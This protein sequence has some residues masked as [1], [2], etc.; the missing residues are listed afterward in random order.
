MAAVLQGGDLATFG[1]VP[2]VNALTLFVSEADAEWLGRSLGR[3]IEV[4][5]NSVPAEMFEAPRGTRRPALVTFVG[6]LNHPPN[7]D[8]VE[9]LVADIW[10]RVVAAF[11]L[12]TGH[13]VTVAAGTIV[14]E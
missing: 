7:T 4:I 8:A 13:H 14:V 1:L 9:W 6:T 12:D 3:P 10:P 11:C 5:E 2:G